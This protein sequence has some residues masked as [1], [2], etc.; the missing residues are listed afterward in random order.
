[1]KEDTTPLRF[2]SLSDLHR[3]LGLPKPL[4]PLITLNDYGDIN[5]PQETL[6]KSMALD[7]YKVSYKMHFDGK[8]R[9]GQ[10]YYDFN[11]GG[12]SFVAPNQVLAGAEGQLDYSGYTLLFHKDFI[13]NYPL[14]AKI[15]N[16]GFFSY[17]LNESLFLSEKEKTMIFSIFDNIKNELAERIDDFSQDVMVAHLELLLSYSNRFYKRQFVTRRTASHD[18]LENMDQLLEHFFDVKETNNTG[19]LTV[20][21]LADQLNVSPRY[22]SDMLRSLTGRS[23]QQHIHDKLI[24][25]AKEYLATTKLTVSE[26]AYLLGFEHSQSLSRVFKKKTQSAPLEYRQSL[27]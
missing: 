13:R 6:R 27:N 4:H 17:A 2:N 26:I 22:L 3:T 21:Y 9:Y 15:K 8:L 25:K 12:L 18:I 5:A 19:Y 14:G 7:F 20:E 11:E 23:A 24:E 10:H 1:M 16:Y